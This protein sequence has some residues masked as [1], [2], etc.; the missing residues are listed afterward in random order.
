MTSGLARMRLS[1]VTLSVAAVALLTTACGLG[2]SQEEVDQRDA[3]IAGLQEQVA[4]LEQDL[5]YWRQ[6]TEFLTPVEMASMSDHRAF[7]TDDGVV[8]ALHFDSLDLGQAENLNWVAIGLPGVFCADDRERIE[9]QFGSGFTHFHDMANDTHGG[10][11]GAEGA[12][13]IHSA[14]R[15]FEAPWGQVTAGVDHGFMPT[16]APAC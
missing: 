6:L 15:D 5:V 7:M 12:W 8:F 13:F 14:V 9:S 11:P 10:E 3:E 16:E 2:S 1:R 4:V